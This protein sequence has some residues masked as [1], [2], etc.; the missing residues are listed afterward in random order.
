MY[1]RRLVP[2]F[3]LLASLTFG[4][5]QLAYAVPTFFQIWSEDIYPDS[6]SDDIGCQLCHQKSDGGDGWNAYGFDIRFYYLDVERDIENAFRYAESINSD[7]D[8]NSLTNL[9]E[10]E[11]SMNPG[12]VNSN[13]NTIGF[14]DFSFLLNQAP[15]FQEIELTETTDESLCFSIIAQ[16]GKVVSICL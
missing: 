2:K 4:A 14:K 11:R 13:T 16:T 5:S 9:Q 8:E 15:P 1:R 10:I 7:G 3:T 12:W 6:N